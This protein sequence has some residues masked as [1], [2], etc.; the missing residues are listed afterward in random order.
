MTAKITREDIYELVRAAVTEGLR[1]VLLFMAEGK[2]IGAYYKFPKNDTF[3][4]S[5]LP[6]FR[7]CWP[8][9][10]PSDYKTVFGFGGSLGSFF[11]EKIDCDKLESWV[12]FRDFAIND[13]ALAHRLGLGDFSTDP[14][15][16][17]NLKEIRQ[18]HGTYGT[19]ARFV[20]RY[21]Y[22]AGS[23]GFVED[24]FSPIYLEWETSMFF[25][26]LPFEIWVPIIC[27]RFEPE[28][29]DLDG[30]NSIEKMPDGLQ[31]AR[32]AEHD[33]T[34]LALATQRVLIGAA[35]HAL[36]LRSWTLKNGDHN[37]LSLPTSFSNALPLI[38]N[39]FAALR[40]VVEA[41][42]GYSQIVVKPDGWGDS[43]KASLPHIYLAAVRAYPE[44][45][46]N[47]G[48]IRP[49]PVINSTAAFEIAEIFRA[50][51]ELKSG[52]LVVAVKRLNAAQLRKE[53]ADSILDITIALEALLGDDA[54]SEMTHKLAMRMAA[55]TKLAPFGTETVEGVFKLVKEIYNYR[56]SVVHGSKKAPK[57]RTISMHGSVEVPLIE[58]GLK[59]LRHAIRVLTKSP[60]F[61]DPTR[62][63]RYLLG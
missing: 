36:V 9:E 11:R 25:E 34:E 21:I 26:T 37:A 57:K 23:F 4:R 17:P 60:E 49:V 63:D 15:N 62:L 47:F 54:K 46:E 61:L 31:L 43:W 28:K 33:S 29:I 55:L 13:S 42:T 45:L 51:N 35:T 56:S 18:R 10:A 41:E 48:W 8:D 44:H 1:S 27:V 50:L 40:I 39:F 7:E 3:E 24:R 53:E 52:G 14:A 58:S 2:H 6:H 38:E 12:R 19:L 5:G 20:D 16:F 32:N 30:L 22:L 59:L